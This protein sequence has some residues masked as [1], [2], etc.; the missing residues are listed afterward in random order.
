MFFVTTSS[1]HP[2][3][4]GYFEVH[5][6]TLDQARSICFK[7]LGEKWCFIY[8]TLDSIHELDQKKLG[9]LGI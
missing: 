8:T 1:S 7:E 5:A 9:E 2:T 4:A 3:G 6:D